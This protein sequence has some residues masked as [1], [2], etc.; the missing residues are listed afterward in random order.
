MSKPLTLP[1]AA[2]ALGWRFA[3][4]DAARDKAAAESVAVFMLYPAAERWSSAPPLYRV[5][6]GKRSAVFEVR[7]HGSQR[8]TSGRWERIDGDA[9]PKG[10]AALAKLLR[11]WHGVATDRTAQRDAFKLAD[12]P[13]RDPNRCATLPRS[14]NAPDPTPSGGSRKG[15]GPK[16]RASHEATFSFAPASGA[17]CA[18]HKLGH[19]AELRQALADIERQ[20]A[21][22]VVGR[23][24][25]T[26]SLLRAEIARMEASR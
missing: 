24:N 13:S 17:S 3:V 8:C 15:R 14:N 12:A 1:S 5:R 2:M 16:G 6:I 9:R 25:G 21:R 23:F 4:G 18:G 7:A 10:A 22:G 19:L 20:N 26:V 11:W